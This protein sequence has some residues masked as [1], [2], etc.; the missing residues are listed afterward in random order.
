MNCHGVQHEGEKGGWALNWG[1]MMR[2]AVRHA[3][4][5]VVNSVRGGEPS[6]AVRLTCSCLG[7]GVAWHL[8]VQAPL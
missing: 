7:F 4:E 8:R 6:D 5:A 2:D 1:L 3:K